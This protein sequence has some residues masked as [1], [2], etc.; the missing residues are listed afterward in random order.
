[1]AIEVQ[2]PPSQR[3]TGQRQAA[4]RVRPSTVDPATAKPFTLQQELEPFGTW[5]SEPIWVPPKD[6]SQLLAETML[7]QSGL[8]TS[9]EESWSGVFQSHRDRFT[10]VR[11]I[12]LTKASI[13]LPKAK[14]FVTVTEQK[15]FG[16]ITDSIPACVQT[17]LDEFL[18][19]PGKRRGVKVYYLKPLCIE[20]DDELIFTSQDD[21]MAAI[22]KIQQE[23]F[24][25]YRRLYLFRRP[26]HVTRAVVDR[27]LA[28]PRAIFK[29][30]MARRQRALDA[31]QAKLEFQRRKTALRAA[32]THKR[33]RTDGCTFDE[34]L[35]LTNPLQR[36]DVIEQFGI[37]RNLS[38]AKRD[39]MIRMAAG[40]L[41]WFVALSL[42]ASYL[43]TIAISIT[44]TPPVLVCD[45]VFVAELPGSKGTVLKIGHFDE[46]AGVKHVE[47]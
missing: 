22:D 26:K 3:Q 41:P 13:R 32:K 8:M 12:E 15:D 36:T 42:T 39:Q 46:I 25:E 24:S 23:V 2:V 40:H 43:S 28:V 20:V 33:F 6:C 16:S 5:T 45:P 18:E 17:R 7:H 30:A 4:N 38:R 21:L 9:K 11:E 14:L 47:I 37:E 44:L 10:Q 29:R 1:M 27:S 35:A 34:M 31:Y 19:G